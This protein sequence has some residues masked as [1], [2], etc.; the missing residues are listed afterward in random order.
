LYAAI[1]V[2]L[3]AAFILIWRE[4][5]NQKIVPEYLIS[6]PEA[7]WKNLSELVTNGALTKHILATFREALGGYVLGTVVGVIIGL[8][9][10]ALPALGK[11]LEPFVTMFNAVPRY[12]LAPLFLIW[13]GFGSASKIALVFAIVVFV[14][15]VNTWQG[16]RNVDPEIVTIS[17]LLGA[18]RT[19]IILKVIFPSTFPWIIAGMRLSIAYALGGAVVGE[20][21]SSQE[22]IGYLIAAGSGVLNMGLVFAGVVVVMMIAWLADNVSTW[23][24][25]RIL[26]WRPS[27]PIG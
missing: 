14:L 17:R 11:V 2:V 15:L 21:F 3:V 27:V 22:G 18:S 8:T 4:I 23:A 10:A 12:A 19:Q 24:E 16:A 7:V 9:F 20:L 13:F 6:R 1:R 5:V 26:R 25:D